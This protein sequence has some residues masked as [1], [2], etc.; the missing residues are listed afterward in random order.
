MCVYVWLS[1]VVLISWTLN[2][3][4]FFIFYFFGIG[5]HL[6]PQP[7][8]ILGNA[9]V[10]DITSK[11]W[12]Q[13]QIHSQAHSVATPLMREKH[14]SQQGAFI[15]E[16]KKKKLKGYLKA[17]WW[18]QNIQGFLDWPA[19]HQ[20]CAC[21]WW[22]PRRG[23]EGSG[24]WCCEVRPPRPECLQVWC[25]PAGWQLYPQLSSRSLRSARAI[26]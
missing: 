8:R 14:Q 12:T 4:L 15:K 22:W 19:L 5:K 2:K 25:R 16:K 9:A 13:S 18:K 26:K 23:W 21:Q 17:F 20:H 11:Q 7:I 6:N 3:D 24:G 10:S 1:C